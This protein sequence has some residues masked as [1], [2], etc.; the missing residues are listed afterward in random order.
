MALYRFF[1]ILYYK[2]YTFDLYF[3]KVKL[4]IKC[5]T[6]CLGKDY[7]DIFG[8]KDY[9]VIYLT[10]KAVSEF[11]KNEKKRYFMLTET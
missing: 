11:T 1:L 3:L 5:I 2:P 8:L 9:F 6:I 4:N 7:W 10:E